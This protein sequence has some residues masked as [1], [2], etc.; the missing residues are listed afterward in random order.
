[1]YLIIDGDDIGRELE[2]HVLTQDI[3]G[4]QIFTELV[5][6]LLNGIGTEAESLGGKVVWKAGDSLILEFNN[7]NIKKIT[8]MVKKLE[9]KVAFSLG[10]GNELRDAWVALK[11]AKAHKPSAVYFQDGKFEFL[12]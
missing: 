4:L 7:F 6:T 10:S 8:P 5:T 1:M 12:M 2:R 9:G 3:P 11:F